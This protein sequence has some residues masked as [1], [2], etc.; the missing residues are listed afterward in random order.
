[1]PTSCDVVPP[2]PGLASVGFPVKV[3]FAIDIC[4][5]TVCVFPTLVASVN[6]GANEFATSDVVFEPSLDGLV[7]ASTKL[8]VRVA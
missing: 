2:A 8:T 3:V 6:P 5:V 1:M 7:T 4:T